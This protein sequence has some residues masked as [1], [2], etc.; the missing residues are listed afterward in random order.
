MIVQINSSSIKNP[1][2]G[3]IELNG[4]LVMPDSDGDEDLELGSLSFDDDETPVIIVGSHE[5]RGSTIKLKQPFAVLRKRKRGESEVE[6]E[7]VGMVTT[8]ILFDQY[9]KSIMR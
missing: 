7:V 8:K 6:Y 4:E 1:E 9:P 5:L 3:L 2:W